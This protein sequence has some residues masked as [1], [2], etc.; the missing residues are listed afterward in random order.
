MLTTIIIIAVAFL[1]VTG[2][3]VI[4]SAFNDIHT[5]Y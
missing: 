1:T 2:I 5:D 4:R 3:L